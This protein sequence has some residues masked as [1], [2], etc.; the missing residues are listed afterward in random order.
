VADDAAAAILVRRS[1]PED[2]D[3]LV[4]L[5]LASAAHH[6]ALEPETYRLPDRA[7]VAA[8]LDRRLSDPAREVL[9]AVVDGAVVGMVDVTLVEP[10]DPGSILRPI[11]TADLG[12]SVLAPW[13]GSG[14]GRALMA[15]AE[16]SARARGAEQIVLDMAASNTG[17]LRF[18]RR[19]GYADHGL[20]L[21]RRLG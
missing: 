9:V 12:I 18:Y 10:P 17:A 19:L 20:L 2:R 7:A 13:R 11:L 14:V 5:D 6:A 21:R 8:F 3:A 16:A 1:R 4:E 15:A